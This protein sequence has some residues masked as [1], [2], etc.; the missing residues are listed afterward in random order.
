MA[1]LNVVVLLGVDQF[2]AD[3]LDDIVMLGAVVVVNVESDQ[4]R[5]HGILFGTERLLLFLLARYFIC[6]LLFLFRL[7]RFLLFEH[8]LKNLSIMHFRKHVVKVMNGML[9]IRN[10]DNLIAL[11]G[12][13]CPTYFY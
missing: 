6:L 11:D 3:S 2:L 5:A 13:I 1:L 4:A 7:F 10:L 9:P 12:V 8:I